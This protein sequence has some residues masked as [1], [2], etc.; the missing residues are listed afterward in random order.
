MKLKENTIKRKNRKRLKPGG[1]IMGSKYT[2]WK[3]IRRS[4]YQSVAAILTIFLTFLLG[5]FFFLATVT[6]VLVINYFESKP[7]ITVFFNDKVG[8]SEADDLKN[9]LMATNKISAAKYISKNDALAI[10]KQ[11]NKNDP[12]LLEMVTADILPASLEISAIDPKFLAE[13][14]P[15]I[16]KSTGIE[17]VVYQKDV[18]NSLITWTNAIRFIGGTLAGLLALDSILII[19]TVISMKIAIRRDE[20]EILRLVGASPWYIRMPFVLE[21]GLYG[22]FGSS[23]AWIIVTILVIFLKSYILSFLGII[24]VVKLVLGNLMDLPFLLS[25]GAFFGLML[26]T[27]FILGAVGS[28]MAVGRFLKI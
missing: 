27:G 3:H 16:K 24:P 19:I 18:V 11:Q 5:G 17:E 22:F 14:E 2:A 28:L 15:I 13:I 9:T 20:I 4:P 8:Q 21:G 12:L 25:S 7:Q 26:L 10:Y 6:S 23:M 1:K